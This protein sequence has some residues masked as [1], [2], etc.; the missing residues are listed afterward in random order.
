M[1]RALILALVL[2]PTAA[3]AYLMPSDSIL[4]RMG[5]HRR[6][7]QL[8]SL[9]VSGKFSL[10]GDSAR[11]VAAAWGL[12]E[13]DALSVPATVTYK[14]PGRCRVELEAQ[15]GKE[16]PAA[17]NVNGRV[18]TAGPEVPALRQ[19]AENVCPL[20]SQQ[21]GT[22]GPM[23]LAKAAGINLSRVELGRAQGNVVSYVLGGRSKTGVVPSLWIEKERFAPL[24]LIAKA[25]GGYVE[26]RL[27]DY[28]SAVSGEWHPRIVEL[29]RGEERTGRFV[30]ERAQP[31]VKVSDAVF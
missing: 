18:S 14:M 8:G 11:A 7:L 29:Y 23:S 27:I 4:R 3:Q 15:P 26:A 2:V 1:K 30:A 10:D 5:S 16:A 21:G 25:G 20:L 17:S 19:F 9:V 12:A 6:N 24:R 22:D 28:S 31:N 13:T